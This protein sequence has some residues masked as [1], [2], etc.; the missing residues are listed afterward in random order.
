MPDRLTDH[1][2]DNEAKVKAPIDAVKLRNGF[3]IVIATPTK[4]CRD[5]HVRLGPMKWQLPFVQS[6]F[7]QGTQERIRCKVYTSVRNGHD[8]MRDIKHAFHE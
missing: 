6:G 7:L 8:Q 3:R 4:L 5:H 1:R 2:C